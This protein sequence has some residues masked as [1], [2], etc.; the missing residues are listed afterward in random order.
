MNA[1]SQIHQEKMVLN[2]PLTD[3][4]SGESSVCSEQESMLTVPQLKSMMI[5][6]MKY[7]VTY[8]KPKKF[9]IRKKL[10]LNIA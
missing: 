10:W 4:S 2:D 9:E 8:L 3:I 1:L 7:Y 5:N 6:T